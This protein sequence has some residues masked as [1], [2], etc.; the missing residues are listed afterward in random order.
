MGDKVGKGSQTANQPGR[1]AK[2]GGMHHVAGAAV[3]AARPALRAR[4]MASAGV[5]T[6]WPQIVGPFLAQATAP[7][8]LTPGR[9]HP[10]GGRE[11][12]VLHLR[13]ASGAL[14]PEIAHLSPQIVEKVNGYYG[15]RAVGRLHIIH[16]PV[17]RPEPRETAAPR[18]KLADA[19]KEAIRLATADIEDEGLR[20]ALQRLGESVA[21]RG[22]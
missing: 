3:K 9:R 6:D 16:A 2:R 18:R 13:V 15:Y 22:G 7:E 20:Q 4:G 10:D 14:A 17:S 19:E 8:K 5:I 1:P 11:P 21:S 12:G